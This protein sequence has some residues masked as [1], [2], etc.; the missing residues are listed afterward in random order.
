[1]DFTKANIDNVWKNCPIKPPA[2]TVD[3][4]TFCHNCV[5]TPKFPLEQCSIFA[6]T[7]VYTKEKIVLKDLQAALNKESKAGHCAKRM[8]EMLK[9]SNQQICKSKVK[10][11]L[12]YY[13]RVV[14][15]V[16]DDATV[17]K[18]F[19]P[20]DFGR[21]GIVLV[22]GKKVRTVGATAWKQGKNTELDL[23]LTLNAGNHVIEYYGSEKCCDG[24][25][26]W[27]FQVSGSK[28]MPFTC[29]NLNLFKTKVYT[30]SNHDVGLCPPGM[31]K[32]VSG[33]CIMKGSY[34]DGNKDCPDGSD[35]NNSQCCFK[36][37]PFYNSKVCGCNPYTE[38]PCAN[39]DCI[40]KDQVCDGKPQCSD[41][42]D[43]GNDKC[44]FKKL[45]FYNDKRCGCRK[46]QW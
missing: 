10:S 38:L 1:M 30:E 3:P 31:F 7:T 18:F 26:A 27:S 40:L 13:Y 43:E 36:K 12:G 42:S 32:C 6:K 9:V 17:Y 46:D 16:A 22:D 4:K 19:T 14:F 8:H 45:W 41:K 24:T 21:G 35:E 34:C 23:T 5:K 15:P 37:F 29:K 28:K 20:T 39:G 25:T 2:P 33:D 11:N 44:C